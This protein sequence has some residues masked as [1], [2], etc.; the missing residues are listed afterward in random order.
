MT[1]ITKAYNKVRF[2]LNLLNLKTRAKLAKE[3]FF[4]DYGWI[5]L[6][7]SDDGDFQ[8]VLYHVNCLEYYQNDMK[9]Y[10]KYIK[11][12]DRVIDVGT[13]LG[14]VATMFASIVGSE[15][16]VFC[17]EPSKYIFS[18]LKKTIAANNLDSVI[19]PFNVGCGTEK[20]T[21]KLNAV[22][23]SSGN[24]SIINADSTIGKTEEIEIVP[25]DSIDELWS[26]PINFIKIDTEGFEPEVL[27]GAKRLITTY[28]PTIYIEMGGSY[29]ESTKRSLAI[30]EE[31]GY[32]T[33][34]PNNINWNEIGDG[35]NFISIPQ[36]GIK[37]DQ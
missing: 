14:F 1:L 16:R 33:L 34:L 5:K 18:K 24:S 26:E 30:L 3:E 35:T 8:E 13:N 12:G 32:Q 11:P 22:S 9:L 10:Q 4:V 25:L 6:L 36:A 31:Y 15:G 23:T 7:F 28:K 27:L 19:T 2:N 20:T 37:S 29:M 17:F 21:V